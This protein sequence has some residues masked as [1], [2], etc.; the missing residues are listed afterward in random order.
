MKVVMMAAMLADEMV[1]LKVDPMVAMSA[2]KMVYSKVVMMVLTKD[3]KKVD[4]WVLK[5]V[6]KMGAWMDMIRAVTMV[7]RQVRILVVKM[8]V[9]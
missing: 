6:E 3:D 1:G 5:M 7:L 4:Q 9:E 8:V 2:Y